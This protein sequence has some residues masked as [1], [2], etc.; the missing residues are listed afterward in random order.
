V[1]SQ[2]AAS[3][4][5]YDLHD[6]L[7][8]YR[9]NGVR[10]YVVWRVLDGSIDWFCLRDGDYVRVKPDAEGIIESEVFPGLR[11]HIA[12]MLT[13]DGAGVLA[14]LAREAPR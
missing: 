13:G 2:V 6:K 10:E 11:L 7:C 14:E 8:A 9:R 3:S 1:Q 12:K 5:S 4:A